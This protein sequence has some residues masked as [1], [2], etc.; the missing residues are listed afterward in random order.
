MSSTLWP[1][2][3][4]G[5]TDDLAASRSRALGNEKPEDKGNIIYTEIQAETRNELNII[6]P[7][8][9]RDPSP[10]GSG[11]SFQV[12]RLL[13]LRPRWP[14]YY[15][16]VKRVIT[17]KMTIEDLHQRLSVIKRELRVLIHRPLRA[18][19]CIISILG[20][21]HSI[22]ASQRMVPYLV[23]EFSDHGT[24]T[25]YLRRCN[26]PLK[27]RRELAL[28]VGMALR[29][30]HECQIIHGDV[31]MD[32]V[33]VFDSTDDL[34][35]RPQVAKLADFG[36][37]LFENDFVERH[38]VSYLGTTKYNAP[39]VASREGPGV[40][41]VESSP[42]LYERADVYSF[43]L[44][45]LETILD[46]KNFI[47]AAWLDQ[48]VNDLTTKDRATSKNA[49]LEFLDKVT[50]EEDALLGL[51][52]GFASRLSPDA[53]SDVINSVTQAM[54]LC[55][56]DDVYKR[57]T[58]VQV[59]KALA[60][61]TTEN[62]PSSTHTSA[63]IISP[64]D[65][66][67]T[68]PSLHKKRSGIYQLHSSPLETLP[69]SNLSI[70]VAKPDDKNAIAE[71]HIGSS[72]L[73][74]GPVASLVAD[75]SS[76]YRTTEIDMFKASITISPPWKVQ[77]RVAERLKS[78]L[79][80]ERDPLLKAQLQLHL[81]IVYWLGYGTQPKLVESLQNL[82]EAANANKI[83]QIIAPR[84]MAAAKHITPLVEQSHLVDTEL[85][86]N[87]TNSRS[88]PTSG[89]VNFL[90]TERAHT[91]R[92]RADAISDVQS[93][94]IMACMEGKFEVAR[95][96]IPLCG[97]FPAYFAPNP[98][99][100]LVMFPYEEA[101][102]LV[103]LLI[104]GSANVQGQQ[105]GV[106][107]TVI[108]ASCVSMINIPE[109]CMDLF[110]TPLHFAVRCGFQ[111][112]VSEFI[113][114]G[115]DVNKRWEA[116][117]I[118]TSDGRSV[119]YPSFSPL[120]VA[121]TYHL[122]DIAQLLLGAGA[123][124]Y[125]GDVDWEYSPLHMVGQKTIPFA[126][127]VMHGS[128]SRAA[129]TQIIRTLHGWGLDISNHDSSRQ[130]PLLRAAEYHDIDDYILEELLEAGARADASTA[131]PGCSLATLLAQQCADRRF[132]SSKFRLFLPQVEDFNCL[133][134]HG[135]GAL[136]YCALFDGIEMARVLLAQ[137]GIDVDCKANDEGRNTPL[138]FAA[139]FGSSDVADLLIKGD[140]DFELA[141][142]DGRSPLRVAV[143]CRHI[144]VA[145]LLI[146]ASASLVFHTQS[147]RTENILHYAVM[148]ESQLPS[149]MEPI[150]R[151][152]PNEKIA[153]LLDEFDGGGWT[154]LHYASY[155]GD[156]EGVNALLEAGANRNSFK[157][158]QYA[159]SLSSRGVTPLQLITLLRKKIQRDGLG[160][161][162]DAV[163]RGGPVAETRFMDRLEQ[164][165]RVLKSDAAG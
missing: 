130:T 120:D 55:L 135:R 8:T 27:E 52:R 117:I 85:Y 96:L 6:G 15:V 80:V 21:G 50:L 101:R 140:A 53:E 147:G 159:R 22:D 73:R 109:Y 92:P 16:A 25:Q 76:Q 156:L 137:P 146:K 31:K 154:P 93:D 32:N 46:G 1:P 133:D 116:R 17:R 95:N 36:S 161:D 5:I 99:H 148:R 158:P 56:R 66:T 107:R 83:A 33:L 67:S 132:N 13:F 68:T 104:F 118:P 141:D 106:C 37:A 155:F 77:L 42:N 44:L 129:A 139:T 18:H 86:Y 163:K 91:P 108:N 23:M 143:T 150:L 125:G 149:L 40:R 54:T 82:A 160:K 87:S 41:N 29:S 35:E 79:D 112:L 10:L 57:G 45:L 51:A 4:V 134:S 124:T 119:R 63:R 59:T 152:L 14:N 145:S 113:R 97:D 136:H 165:E 39:E 94:L 121:A 75:P 69:S 19:S 28:D 24:L 84:V 162:H 126:R 89:I 90:R 7:E 138:L 12:D 43:G 49:E 151:M 88:C 72:K 144:D 110:G 128:H 81:T 142:A 3:T 34:L 65:S 131:Y 98:L 64:V 62:R 74:S 30:L 102:L 48:G 122:A 9:L 71:R 11:T 157:N 58:M 60:R 70:R 164:I 26:I 103:N 123:V 20:Y 61:G 2:S 115:A 38:Y 47:D 153:D 127:F 114:H 111:D 105:H 78:A 100:W